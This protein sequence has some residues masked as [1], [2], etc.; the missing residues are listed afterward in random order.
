MSNANTP[1]MMAQSMAESLLRENRALKEQNALLTVQ[2]QL[3]RGALEQVVV[4]DQPKY[5][6]GNCAEVAKEAISA[7][8]QQVK[9]E[10]ARDAARYRHVR[11]G[12][13]NCSFIVRQARYDG[14]WVA[15]GCDVLD[16]AIDAALSAQD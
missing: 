2:V 14:K 3:L 5:N 16:E 9:S 10:D 13:L 6:Y 4:L 1:A 7:L 11:S 8:P 15:M 12:I